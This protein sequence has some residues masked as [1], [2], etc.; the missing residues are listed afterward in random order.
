MA[1]EE[2][3]ENLV[4]L[5]ATLEGLQLQKRRLERQI[6]S[7]E[8]LLRSSSRHPSSAHLAELIEMPA[9]GSRLSEEGRAR[10]SAAQK[11]R[12]EQ[13]RRSSKKSVRNGRAAS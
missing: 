4:L 7:I 10:I 8:K 1:S 3:S 9:R 6:A 5:S 11:R 2:P 13:Y 12:W